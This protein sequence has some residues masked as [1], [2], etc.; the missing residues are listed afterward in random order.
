MVASDNLRGGTEGI[1]LAQHRIGGRDGEFTDR[2]RVHHIAKIDYADQ[3]FTSDS[4]GTHQDIVIIGIVV[5]NTLTQGRQHGQNMGLE[6]LHE[7]LNNGVSFW[8]CDMLE[9][10]AD[11]ERVLQIPFQCSLRSAVLKVLECM[12]HLP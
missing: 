10:I 7:V 1:V 12:I 3:R 8:Y 9:I 4:G 6:L 2:I 5:N 11:P